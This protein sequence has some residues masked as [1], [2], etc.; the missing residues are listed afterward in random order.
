MVTIVVVFMVMMVVHEG[1]NFNVRS[2]VLQ[3]RA[4]FALFGG[5]DPRIEGKGLP[6]DCHLSRGGEDL[7]FFGE[8]FLDCEHVTGVVI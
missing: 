5:W 3:G 2:N 1:F 7:V 6:C 8:V 4:D